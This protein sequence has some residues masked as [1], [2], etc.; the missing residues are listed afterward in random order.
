MDEKEP[1][2][3]TLGRTFPNGGKRM[4]PES[5]LGKAHLSEEQRGGECGWNME[6]EMGVHWGQIF[7]APQVMARD[8]DFVE[9][10]V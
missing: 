1:N 4:C 5:M 10:T 6:S 3:K 9:S 7:R 2:Y 8:L